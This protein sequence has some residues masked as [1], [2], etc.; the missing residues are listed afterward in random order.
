ML[1]RQTCPISHCFRGFFILSFYYMTAV[2][3]NAVSVLE[4]MISKEIGALARIID[5]VRHRL[6][7]MPFLLDE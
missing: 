2:G 1:C 4:V 6:A 3:E 7:P 5:D